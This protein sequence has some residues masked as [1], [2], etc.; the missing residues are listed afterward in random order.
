MDVIPF[1]LRSS[2]F[3]PQGGCMAHISG[4]PYSLSSRWVSAW[5][6]RAGCHSPQLPI[7]TGWLCQ[8][9]LPLWILR[10][11][12]SPPSADLTLDSTLLFLALMCCTIPCLSRALSCSPLTK[13]FKL[14]SVRQ[15]P[16]FCRDPYLIKWGSFPEPKNSTNIE[17]SGAEGS[18]S[19]QANP[20]HHLH[21]NSPPWS[22]QLPNNADF[23]A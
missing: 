13:L 22:K 5:G 17:D 12:L 21:S 9:G 7:A 15:P 14:L 3:L 16:I 23:I 19:Y 1:L 4:L 18:P 6:A 8:A 11:A 2:S 20:W 10:T